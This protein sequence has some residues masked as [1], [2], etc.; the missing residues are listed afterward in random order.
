MFNIEKVIFESPQVIING[1]SVTL[2]TPVTATTFL[3]R[4]DFFK[5]IVGLITV[6]GIPKLSL[7][8]E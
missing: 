7:D 5:V 8:V 2:F 6:D 1:S 3:R 4:I